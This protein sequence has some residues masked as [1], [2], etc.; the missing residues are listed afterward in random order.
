MKNDGIIA[1]NLAGGDELISVRHASEG[2][3]VVIV[4]RNGK[5]IRFSQDDAR[6]MGRATAGVKGI[7]LKRT[8]PC[9][10]WT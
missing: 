2:D 6:P 3:D 4:T 7:T 5:G 1:I 8:T 9:S 10:P